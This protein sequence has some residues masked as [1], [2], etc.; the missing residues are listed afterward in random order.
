MCL[1]FPFARECPQ[2]GG[3][4]G[5]WIP[6]YAGRRRGWVQ[7]SLDSCLRGN[8]TCWTAACAGMTLWPPHPAV[9]W[10]P[11]ASPAVGRGVLDCRLRGNDTVWV[12][13]YAGRRPRGIPKGA[14][15]PACAGMTL[16]SLQPGSASPPP[17]SARQGRGARVPLK[18]PLYKVRPVEAVEIRLTFERFIGP[19][20][21]FVQGPGGGSGRNPPR[22]AA[23][24]GPSADRTAVNL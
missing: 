22:R 14:W 11:P 4:L 17:A 2:G 9:P 6:A 21:R 18:G 20:E 1:R 19:L 24:L 5:V 23:A 8:D 13:A 15:V 3:T 7:R 10:A 12:P 16:G